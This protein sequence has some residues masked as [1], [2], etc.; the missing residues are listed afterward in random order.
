MKFQ[1]AAFAIMAIVPALCAPTAEG[2]VEA[3]QANKMEKRQVSA[4][5]TLVCNTNLDLRVSEEIGRGIFNSVC[6][7]FFKCEH[8]IAPIITGNHYVGGCINCPINPR[9]V[10]GGCLLTRN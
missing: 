2:G 9:A 10:F 6:I 5:N 1:S 3:I 4:Q 8:L 7:G